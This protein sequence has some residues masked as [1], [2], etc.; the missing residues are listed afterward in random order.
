MENS[1]ITLIFK[2]DEQIR[3]LSRISTNK[4]T[5]L[6]N[7][8]FSNL[9]IENPDEVK[10]F[11]D[12]LKLIYEDHWKKF[13]QINT[14]IKLPL[15]IRIKNSNNLKI[16]KFERTLKDTD[17][18]YDFFISKFDNE[19]VYFQV[20]FNGTTDMF[21]KLMSEN[22]FNFNTDKKIWILK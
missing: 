15:N 21:I 7:Q 12:D 17:L 1:I 3:V 6:K 4:K 5:V 22:N 8:T 14:S 13:N 11:I 20:I 19:H 9:D 10:A 2:G 16:S 18:I